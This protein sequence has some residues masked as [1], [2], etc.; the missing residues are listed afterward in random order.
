MF[1]HNSNLNFFLDRAI[2]FEDACSN[3]SDASLRME[4]FP[5]DCNAQWFA[6]HLYGVITG[7]F[8][9]LESNVDDMVV[10]L[11]HSLGFNNGNLLTT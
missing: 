11:F 6:K 8:G 3:I 10:A 9:N 7:K 2:Q 1:L 5:T 4:E